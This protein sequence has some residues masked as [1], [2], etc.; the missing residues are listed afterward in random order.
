[1][2]VAVEKSSPASSSGEH[3]VV[4]VECL[5]PALLCDT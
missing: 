3:T 4:A 2:A 1:M 5:S